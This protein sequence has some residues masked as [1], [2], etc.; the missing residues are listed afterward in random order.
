MFLSKTTPFYTESSDVRYIAYLSDSCLFTT[1][2][3]GRKLK[4][5][6]NVSHMPV[7]KLNIYKETCAS[8]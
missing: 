2:L 8:V 7:Q 4:H 1:H 5:R 6:I 3:P